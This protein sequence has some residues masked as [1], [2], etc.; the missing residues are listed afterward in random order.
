MASPSALFAS[1]LGPM[2]HQPPSQQAT[3]A[4]TLLAFLRRDKSSTSSPSSKRSPPQLECTVERSTKST[5]TAYRVVDE[6]SRSSPPPPPYTAVAVEEARALALEEDL[7]VL[8][9]GEEG[10]RSASSS[11]GPVEVKVETKQ[12]RKEREKRDKQ[13]RKRAQ[14]VEDDRRIGDELARL[15]F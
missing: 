13:E 7:V 11:F 2:H 9:D 1:P 4:R 10:P 8:D 14:L 5:Y 15:G 6:A 12:E 3:A